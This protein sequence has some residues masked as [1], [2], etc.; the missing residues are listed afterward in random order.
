MSN[1]TRSN[2]AAEFSVLA[3]T[4]A[5]K[6]CESTQTIPAGQAF[7]PTPQAGGPPPTR[8]TPFGQRKLWYEQAMEACQARH[9]ARALGW[10]AVVWAATLATVEGST[11]ASGAL[12]TLGDTDLPGV[13]AANTAGSSPTTCRGH[14]GRCRVGRCLADDAESSHACQK[15]GTSGTYSDATERAYL[16]VMGVLQSQDGGGLPEGAQTP[17]PRSRPHPEGHGSGFDPTGGSQRGGARHLPRREAATV[18]ERRTYQGLGCRVGSDAWEMGTRSGQRNGWCPAESHAWGCCDGCRGPDAGARAWTWDA[19][20]APTGSATTALLRDRSPSD[21]AS[22]DSVCGRSCRDTRWLWRPYGTTGSSGAWD[23]CGATVGRISGT[24]EYHPAAPQACG[25]LPAIAFYSQRSVLRDAFSCD[26]TGQ[27]LAY[28]HAPAI[29]CG[30]WTA[31]P[32]ASARIHQEDISLPERQSDSLLEC[33]VGRAA[34]RRQSSS[35]AHSPRAAD[36]DNSGKSPTI[37]SRWTSATER[38]SAGPGDGPMQCGGTAQMRDRGRRRGWP[39]GAYGS[40]WRGRYA[41]MTP[42][43]LFGQICGPDDEDVK[44]AFS[45]RGP[46]DV[47]AYQPW[48][49]VL[50]KFSIHQLP[51]ELRL[52]ALLFQSQG[53]QKTT[54]TPVSRRAPVHTRLK[55]LTCRLSLFGRL[56][57]HG[58]HWVCDCHSCVCLLCRVEV[59]LAPFGDS[60]PPELPNPHAV[61]FGPLFVTLLARTAEHRWTGVACVPSP[62]AHFPSLLGLVPP[63]PR[64]LSFAACGCTRRNKRFCNSGPGLPNTVVP[65]SCIGGSGTA[66]TVYVTALPLPVFAD[67]LEAILSSVGTVC[68]SFFCTLLLCATVALWCLLGRSMPGR[69]SPLGTLLWGLPLPLMPFAR[70]LG[71]AG[72][73]HSPILAWCAADHKPHRSVG[74]TRGAESRWRCPLGFWATLLLTLPVQVWSTPPEVHELVQLAAIAEQARHAQDPPDPPEHFGNAPGLPADHAP[75]VVHPALIPPRGPPPPQPIRWEM[76]GISSSASLAN[77]RHVELSALVLA[78]GYRPEALRFQIGIPCDV[79]DILDS[80]ERRVEAL[81]LRFAN[82]FLAVRPQPLPDIATVMVVPDWAAFAAIS[83]VCI[84]LRDTDPDGSGPIIATFVPRPATK[85]DL[86]R[87]AGRHIR[88][89]PLPCLRRYRKA[90]P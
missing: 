24:T 20:A 57:G 65:K 19:E 4:P 79:E 22:W 82:R 56:S 81:R 60:P 72:T 16:E 52:L 18:C 83:A 33:P 87:Q 42:S 3:Q 89:T 77:L 49:W 44:P 58:H 75:D 6:A 50:R 51:R 67:S 29:G 7:G 2:Y 21:P 46:G 70:C 71:C 34:R 55:S 76:R 59:V 38:C 23:E 27:R 15:G 47:R 85:A 35:Q 86:C 64:V 54:R 25:S 43:R 78:P 36:C 88:C 41:S 66:T 1:E 5:R 68:V 28:G 32:R 10:A 11:F 90:G 13:H 40:R 63:P 62:S 80:V 9:L 37:P 69:R 48:G 74:R 30:R 8:Q 14:G 84:D 61:S 45:S 26:A 31:G 17:P 39:R 53:L 12:A 73:V